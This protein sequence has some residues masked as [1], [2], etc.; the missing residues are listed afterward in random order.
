M[1][2]AVLDALTTR[3]GDDLLENAS[4]LGDLVLVIKKEK[5]LEM[6]LFL[7]E[8]PELAFD[9]PV[10]CTAIDRLDLDVEGE[11]FEVVYALRSLKH[12]HAIRLK[13]RV[14]AEDPAVPSLCQ[15]WT[16]MNWLEREVYDMYG[17]RFDGHPDLRRIY[18]Y[19][20]FKGHPLRK[21]YPKDKR[22]PLVRREWSDEPLAAEQLQAQRKV[23]R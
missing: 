2:Q 9:F 11:R 10:F 6:A 18:M 8:T 16:G 3:F 22:Q 20:Q 14:P 19:E 15:V 13:V 23:S 1:A 21:D 12:R 17:I 4:S 7:R 5:L